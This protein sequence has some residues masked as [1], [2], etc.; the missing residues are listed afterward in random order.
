MGRKKSRPIKSG[1]IVYENSASAISLEDTHL[2]NANSSKQVGTNNNEENSVCTRTIYIDID[3]SAWDSTE[4]F[5][6]A[7]VILCDVNFYNE[8]VNYGLIKDRFNELKFALRFR[9]CNVKEGSFRLGQ[10]PILSAA[11]SIFLEYLSLDDHNTEDRK[12]CSL[13]L[14]GHLDGSDDCVSSLVHL[15]SL[16]FLALRP[17]H[18]IND[19]SEVPPL[20]LRVEVL[21]NAFDACESLLETVRQ[22]WRKSMMNVMSW[23][24]PEVTTSESIYGLEGPIIPT[25][26]ASRNGPSKHTGFDV[27][28]FY[29][30]IKPSRC[31]LTTFSFN[32]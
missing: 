30:A 14:A 7:E 3:G 9:L 31:V 13:I 2:E 12:N 27:A 28:G 22:P 32:K 17:I 24:R 26:D 4:H 21:K 6:I 25:E 1:G 16:K 18:V 5:D 23:L 10:W 8:T 15:V 29:E 11:D 20:R 19:F